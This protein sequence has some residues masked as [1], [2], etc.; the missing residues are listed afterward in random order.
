MYV[1]AFFY[2]IFQFRGK[3][4]I[5]IDCENGIPFFTPLYVRKPLFCLMHHVHQNVFFHSLPKPLAWL[6]SF[7]ETILMPL[8]YRKVRF[9][10]VSESSK[11]EM[12]ALGI[13]KSG[14]SI[15]HPGVN[16]GEFTQTFVEKTTYPTVLYLGRLKAYKSVNVLIQAFRTV[17]A[18]RSDA[19]L[20][21]AGDGD[22]KGDLKRLA[23]DLKFTG[24]Q[25]TFLGTV[26]HEAKVAL[27]QSSW[28]LVNPSFMEGWGIVVI[29][30][31][32][33]GTPVIASNVPGLQDS[34]LDG[35]AGYLLPYG[36][37]AAFSKTILTVI[38]DRELR[39]ELDANA[40]QWAGNFT[41][42]RSSLAFFSAITKK[43]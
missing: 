21:I 26:S 10:T 32:T 28:V 38:K 23:R 24:D 34:V 13:G 14:I 12:E 22:A 8:V 40:R 6:A 25:V 27:L 18:E 31:N 15:V 35:K 11:Q 39:E 33:C 2:Y 7:L 16:A 20:I 42:E 4:D 9:I 29:E 30:A 36:D 5:V 3:Y 37:V 41:W 43:S 17:L 1:W 19:R